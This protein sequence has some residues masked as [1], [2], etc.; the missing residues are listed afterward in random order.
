MSLLI[1][2]NRLAVSCLLACLLIGCNSKRNGPELDT[3]NKATNQTLKSGE[4]ADSPGVK[5]VSL[6][7]DIWVQDQSSIWTPIDELEAEAKFASALKATQTL[8]SQ[9]HKSGASQDVVRGLL[10]QSRLQSQLDSQET[11]LRS[12]A[13][14]KWPKELRSQTALHLHL[15]NA[16]GNYLNRYSWEI[17][18]REQVVSSDQLDLKKWTK[19]QLL[20]E[21]NQR[22]F[23]VWQHRAALGNLSKTSLFDVLAP[24]SF[25][26]EIRGTLRDA[27]I[28]M[29]VTEI[30][31]T[32]TWHPQ[33]ASQIHQLDLESLLS[34]APP[35]VDP[36]DRAIHPLSRVSWL[37]AEHEAWHLKNGRRPAALEAFLMRINQLHSRF[38]NRDSRA[39]TFAALKQRLAQDKDLEWWT[40]GMSL[41]ARFQQSEDVPGAL[42]TAHKTARQCMSK[43]TGSQGA[44]QCAAWASR[45]EEPEWSVQ[46]MKS[47][48]AQKRSI[49]LSYK[50]L[51]KMRFSAWKVDAQSHALSNEGRQYGRGPKSVSEYVKG[52]LLDTKPSYSWTVSLPPTRD[53][54]T[55]TQH[56]KTNIT[57]RGDY[58]I[59]AHR[60]DRP[61]GELMQVILM[62][63]S[64]LVASY[65][66]DDG[67]AFF[68]VNRGDTGGPVAKAKVRFYRMSNYQ[69]GEITLVATQY[70]DALGKTTFVPSRRRGNHNPHFAIID[71][72]TEGALVHDSF[73][74][75]REHNRW[76]PTGGVYVFTDRSA[77][78]PG[79]KIHWQL[80]SYARPTA[81]NEY[82]V[83]PNQTMSV[84]LRDS[85]H[86]TISTIE[87]V[88][89]EFG[90][91][92]GTFEIPQGR[93]LGQWRIQAKG[94]NRRVQQFGGQIQVEAYKR[95]T[96]ETRFLPND[97]SA[98]LNKPTTVTGEARYY[99]GLPVTAGK[100]VWRVNRVPHYPRW[101]RWYG[102]PTQTEENIASGVAALNDEGQFKFTFTPTA[103]ERLSTG[104]S[105]SVTYRYTFSV[106]VTDE[107]GETRSASKS[108]HLGF[109][110]IKA[111][112]HSDSAFERHD[113]DTT[114]HASRTDLDG[115]PLAGESQWSL[116]P[117]TQPK[118]TPVPSQI[119]LPGHGMPN[120]YRLLDDSLRARFDH[121]YQDHQRL[122]ASWADDTAVQSGNAVHNKRGKASIELGQL[123]P[124]A[125]RLRYASKD[126]FG[127]LYKTDKIFIVTGPTTPLAVPVALLVDYDVRAAGET[128]RLF[129]HSGFK[130]QF[131]VLTRWHK[132][133]VVWQREINQSTVLTIPVESKDRGGIGFTLDFVRDHQ[134]VQ[135]RQKISVPWDNKA[136]DVR[137]ST[138]RDTLRPGQKET[139]SVDV[140]THSGVPAVGEVLAYM[141]D[142]SLELFA[143]HRP[144][145]PLNRH[146]A[147]TIRFGSLRASV[148]QAPYHTLGQAPDELI[149]PPPRYHPTGLSIFAMSGFGFS[150]RGLGGGG[151]GIGVVSTARLDGK[152]SKR[153]VKA[154]QKSMGSPD[155]AHEIQFESADIGTVHGAVGEKGKIGKEDRIA[156]HTAPKPV[157]IR[158]NFS[159]TAFF[160]PQLLLDT[161]G[162]AK[163][164]FQVPD[165]V[166]S[167]NVYVHAITKDLKYGLVKKEVKTVKDLMVRPYLPRFL[168][169][170]DEATL[171]VVVN[172]ASDAA[173]SGRVDIDLIDPDTQKSR[174]KDFGLTRAQVSGL[175]FETPVGQS[176]RL[177]VAVKAPADLGII[178][179]KITA[180]TDSFSDGEL[181]S[182][183]LLP[184][185]M[186]LA[187]SR[188]AVLRDVV[189]KTLRFDDLAKDD[190]PSRI[191][192]SV[193]V[194]LDGQLFYGV[195]AALP[196]L[197]NYPY[198]CTEQT[199]NRFVSTG[200]LSSMYA[201]YPAVAKMA[202][203]LAKRTTRLEDFSA[204]D[205]NR[206]MILEETPWLNEARGGGGE[207]LLNVLDPKVAQAH[208]RSALAKLQKSQLP[209]GGFPWFP[210]GRAS[211]YMTL[212]LMYG[213]AKAT[214]FG[215]S[216]PKSITARG[217][218]Y[219]SGYLEQN[220]KPC[221]RKKSCVHQV[222][223][224]NYILSMYP[225]PSWYGGVISDDMRG[226]MLDFSFSKWKAHS[227][228]SKSMLAL[229]LK[230]FGRD[231]DARL[232]WDSVLDRAK[233]T[234]SEGTFWAPED[235]SWLWYNDTIESH[236]MAIRTT[237]ELNPKE[238]KLDGMILWLFLNKKLNHWKSTRATS[239]VIYALAAYLKKTDQLGLREETRVR[240]GDIDKTFVFEPDTFSGKKNQ[241]VVAG[242]DVKPTKHAE[243]VFDKKSK[244]YQLASATWHFSTER[245][246]TDAEGDFLTVTRSYF[247]RSK[248]GSEI[249]LQPLEPGASVA[250]G[251]EVEVQLSITSKH[252]LEYVQLRD[253]RAAG[254]EPTSS[255]SGHKWDMGI[256]WY[257]EVRDS[258]TNFFFERLPHGE[259]TFKYRLRAATQG[260]FK[261]G[262]AVIQPVYAPEF[263]G[264]SSGRIMTIDAQ[265]QP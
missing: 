136:L 98:R 173:L 163:I 6:P 213:F 175:K 172:N 93:M 94:H 196:Y 154:L 252:A 204:H 41:L 205:P 214:E 238:P 228:H 135:L 70:T 66:S 165:S 177:I 223:F 166:T 224:L 167:W 190:D 79:Q 180:S 44:K 189:K 76:R 58:V 153:K 126:A 245:L 18:S 156:Q 103:D 39:Q 219:L 52:D 244:G 171:Q 201:E 22:Y 241:I 115:T 71:H 130:D 240:I 13:M 31:N 78:R 65:R 62:N 87:G 37:L 227:L 207:D 260:V 258:S 210:G 7:V 113:E 108:M 121:G 215:V 185:R 29:W 4:S 100:A 256:R 1:Q 35:S 199:L 184:G 170:G 61:D 183:P 74:L 101:W 192:D 95:P 239:E 51:K 134:L 57:E 117:L 82:K 157:R 59:V 194:T 200:I 10:R 206:K 265:T 158:S 50:N 234:E 104:K 191:N 25:P 233:Q 3:G 96:F 132:N 67:K 49:R 247:R 77:Y 178:A 243:V 142:R 208:R 119:P 229:T 146:D 106:D 124:G 133:K 73:Y 88:S 140:K 169:E 127:A 47:D 226:E 107:G 75:G 109:V 56:V 128:A 40:I 125:Y 155:R 30:S 203:S 54:K 86:E 259:Y 168:R 24:G 230:R 139:W 46:S 179:V 248:V 251:D 123:K 152:R 90:T 216:V 193:V 257:E 144:P 149:T 164:S 89:N 231:E 28:Y 250:V 131:L 118:R 112:L 9:L 236:A 84:V 188:F 5:K 176:A 147:L 72:P 8:L 137:F 148:G 20:D 232:V 217:W 36:S 159:E 55:H 264:Y 102:L 209:D 211:S 181:R 38:K 129:V 246:P 105:R 263:V 116:H 60:N 222:T 48:D 85:N 254:F 34:D 225:D 235:R 16:F 33:Q 120:P 2:P 12:L 150:G 161:Q 111:E 42:I 63:V 83:A 261:T 151:R 162:R 237:M 218:R 253:P 195:L 68:R 80:V 43:Y 255:R 27:V 145:S 32:T 23:Q 174:I 97:G 99:F 138:F 92:S 17:S 91:L 19:A 220:L 26:K 198:E 182:L 141:H 110:A 143:T 21:S 81:E 187:Q 186:H 69:T 14:A 45:I 202:Q 11:A 197:V 221:M 242:D 262:P 53:Y 212:Y 15:A 64:N 249:T 114:I 160:E 122:V